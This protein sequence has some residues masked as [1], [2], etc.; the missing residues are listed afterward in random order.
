MSFHF[1]LSREYNWH[2]VYLVGHT[3]CGGVK[4]SYD[5]AHRQMPVTGPLGVW[6]QPLISL[7]ISA[8][9]NVM[10][11]E[12]SVL[13]LRQQFGNVAQSDAFLRANRKGEPN[14]VFVALIMGPLMFFFCSDTSWTSVGCSRGAL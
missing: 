5:A 7:S 10:D 2:L 4:A 13:N 11:N 8:G 6:L 14:R 1:K 3:D 12:L 9:A